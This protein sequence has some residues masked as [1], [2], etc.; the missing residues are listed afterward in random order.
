MQRNY[1]QICLV[2]MSNLLQKHTSS[3]IKLLIF[4]L[5]YGII[6]AAGI[7]LIYSFVEVISGNED[8]T[9]NVFYGYFDFRSLVLFA[10]VLIVIRFTILSL[11]GKGKAKLITAVS[12][13]ISEDMFKSYVFVAYSVIR[14]LNIARIIQDIRG[15]T[16]FFTRYMVSVSLIINEI[17]VAFIVIIG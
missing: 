1:C 5:F 9:Q 3:L 8:A 15:E 14:S 13:G 6:D 7:F 17:I 16:V 11:L 2:T 10:L 12:K 4:Q